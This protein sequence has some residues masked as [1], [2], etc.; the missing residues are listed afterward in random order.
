MLGILSFR[1]VSSFVCF[2]FCFC[3]CLV[4]YMGNIQRSTNITEIY[5]WDLCA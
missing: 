1:V 2:C 5:V 3:F 4:M